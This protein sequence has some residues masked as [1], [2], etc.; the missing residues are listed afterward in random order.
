MALKL[1][2]RDGGKTSEEGINRITSRLINA[3]G[4][5]GTND[6]KVVATGTPDNHVNVS[7][8]DIAIGN[9]S[10]NTADP[11]YYY[12]GWVTASEQLTISA[13]ASGNPRIDVVVAYV[14]LS[15]VSSASN[16]NPGALAVKVVAGT[17]AATP[18]APDDT[19]IQTSVGASNPWIPLAEVAVANGFSSISNSNITDRRPVASTLARVADNALPDL[20][21]T[22]LLISQ[23]SGLIGQM[24]TGFAIINGEIVAKGYLKHTFAASKDTYVDLPL[25]SKPTSTDDLTYTAVANGATSG[26]ALAANSVRI[27]KVVTNGS[28]IT[29]VVT[30][31]ID[32]M[33]YKIRPLGTILQADTLYELTAANGVMINEAL[34]AARVAS[35][36]NYF[37]ALAAVTGS[38]PALSVQGSDTNLDFNIVPKGTGRVKKNGNNI[39]TWEELARATAGSSVASI[40]TPTF[41]AKKYLKILQIVIP[42]AS[43]ASIA[44]RLNGDSGSNYYYRVADNG[45]AQLTGTT[46]GI[47]TDTGGSS[48]ENV[49][50]EIFIVNIAGKQKVAVGQAMSDGAG[51]TNIPK[52]RIGFA[53]WNN[54]TD[55]ITSATLAATGNNMAAGSEIIVLG[56]D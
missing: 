49:Q 45:G 23:S 34:Q 51:G 24:T 33:G 36:V 18:S 30:S 13:N 47:P 32:A 52:A 29:S 10:P 25:G 6:L 56:H 9:N 50:A 5:F 38:N 19:A 37:K 3:A 20:V 8:G 16:D 44:V 26:F 53:K 48:T 1:G 28:G 46:S 17:A 42:A 35:A 11:D 43:L 12:H 27:A 15:V 14:D 54:T 41:T 21:G 22:G 55:A 4:V 39:D 40:T 2:Y 31:G 7:T